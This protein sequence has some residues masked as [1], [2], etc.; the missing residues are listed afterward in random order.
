MA[1]G[2]GV[3]MQMVYLAAWTNHT[4]CNHKTSSH[5]KKHLQH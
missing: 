2:D 5:K 1:H 4:N 3:H